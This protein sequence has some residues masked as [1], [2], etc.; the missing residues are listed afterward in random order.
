MMNSNVIS[1]NKVIVQDDFFDDL[2]NGLKTPIEESIEKQDANNSKTRLGGKQLLLFKGKVAPII[3]KEVEKNKM[4]HEYMQYV[5]NT[6]EQKKIQQMH[7]DFVEAIKGYTIIEDEADDEIEDIKNDKKG[8]AAFLFK[9]FKMLNTLRKLMGFYN[10]VLQ[11]KSHIKPRDANSKGYSFDD[12]DFDNPEQRRQ[13]GEDAVEYLNTEGMRLVPAMRPLLFTMTTAIFD[14]S[15][16]AFK[17]INTAIYWQIAK[18]LAQ[19]AAEIGA[20][21]VITALTGGAGSGVWGKVGASIASMMA[22]IGKFLSVGLKF[23]KV[24]SGLYKM[25]KVGRGIVKGTK[26]AGKVLN[27]SARF[28]LEHRKGVWRAYKAARTGLEVIDILNVDE[29]DLK[30]VEEWARQKGAPYREKVEAQWNVVK[31]DFQTIETVN[32][33]YSHVTNRVKTKIHQR[34]HDISSRNQEKYESDVR[35]KNLDFDFETVN[36]LSNYFKKSYIFDFKLNSDVFFTKDGDVYKLVGT[37]IE[38][39]SAAQE[40]RWSKKEDS[41]KELE[42]TDREKRFFG[43]SNSAKVNFERNDR[44]FTLTKTYFKFKEDLTFGL[45]GSKQ[46]VHHTR[47]GKIEKRSGYKTYIRLKEDMGNKGAE[48]QFGQ[49]GSISGFRLFLEYN[50]SYFGGVKDKWYDDVHEMILQVLYKGVIVN[51]GGMEGVLKNNVKTKLQFYKNGEEVADPYNGKI[52]VKHNGDFVD[53]QGFSNVLPK[54]IIKKRDGK[55]EKVEF[56]SVDLSEIIIHRESIFS[57]ENEFNKKI[58]NFYNL[59]Q[60]TITTENLSELRA[61]AVKAINERNQRLQTDP[62]KQTVKVEHKF[63]GSYRHTWAMR[64]NYGSQENLQNVVENMTRDELMRITTINDIADTTQLLERHG[65]GVETFKKTET[66]H[67]SSPMFI[68]H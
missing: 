18:M 50:P 38:F 61:A 43:I 62:T 58:K 36:K 4:I 11:M 22:K 7:N 56:Q 15:Q 16:K 64:Y 2:V 26:I 17:E 12:Y 40:I 27:R 24:A 23:G 42:L 34:I 44:Y 48:I 66:I 28:T 20:S 29:E 13:A 14:V 8:H 49:F 46:S 47:S 21:I 31:R 39:D 63:G 3:G 45:E 35:I 52:R 41:T 65:V 33:A 19:I 5:S 25:G 32:E 30:E 10:L 57:V 6:Y 53:V 37:D 51:I 59:V 68:G 67:Q 60:T 55:G 9:G 1:K 54:F